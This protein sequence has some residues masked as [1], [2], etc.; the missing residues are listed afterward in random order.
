MSWDPPRPC[1]DCGSS[2]IG[3][4]W[5]QESAR[6]GVLEFQC[7]ACGKSLRLGLTQVG[8]QPWADLVEGAR[9]QWD[10]LWEARI[11]RIPK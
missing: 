5:E 8:E 1:S 2:K 3:V 7:L 11:A 10:G 4:R 9:K 6:S